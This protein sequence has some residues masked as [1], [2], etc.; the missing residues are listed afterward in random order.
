MAN[1]SIVN[2]SALYGAYRWDA[3]CYQPHILDAAGALGHFRTVRLG[4]ISYIT[5]GQHGY[6]EVDAESSIRHITARCVEGGIVTDTQADRLSLKTHNAN[7][8]SQLKAGDVLLSTAGTIGEAGIVENDVLPANIDQDVARIALQNGAGIDPYFLVAFLR[9][10]LGRFQS[11]RATTGQIQ[12]HITLNALRDFEIPI[13]SDQ[14]KITEL[15]QRGVA[16][17]RSA[18]RLTLD[19]E[20][21]F[22]NFLGFDRIGLSKKKCYACAFSELQTEARFDAEY[23]SPKYQRIIKRLREEGKTLSDVAQL[24]ERVFTPPMDKDARTFRY[25]EIGSLTGDGRAEFEKVEVAD[26]PS[27]AA[28]IVKPGDIITSTVRPIRRLSAMISA[29]QDGCVCSSGFAVL[30]PKTGDSGIEP[31]VLLTYLRLPVICEILNLHTTASMYPAIPV[32]RL[33]QIPILV[34]DKAVRKQIV[35]KVRASLDACRESIRLLD[36]AKQTVED[37]ITGASAR[38]RR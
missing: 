7:V 34:P 38:K 27:R 30:T 19:A 36:Q 13:L 31:E 16:A 3:E 25:I 20:S 32:Q 22:V 26:A 35:A 1:F 37:M 5:D 17:R 33:M 28:W 9:S 14:S 2:L 6:H 12:M 15:M 24:S 4:D 10:E 29:D 11:A 18:D 21:L 23:F 8:R